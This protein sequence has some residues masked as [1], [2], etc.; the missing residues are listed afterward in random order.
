MQI[1]CL[2]RFAAVAVLCAL[3][4]CDWIGWR[5]PIWLSPAPQ[6][7]AIA[8]VAPAPPAAMPVPK[9][10][11]KSPPPR[12]VPKKVIVGERMPDEVVVKVMEVGRAAFGR[13]FK[14]A[15]D[16]DPLATFKVRLHVELDARGRVTSI[17]A[18]TTNEALASCLTRVG[19]GLPY[20]TTGRPVVVDLPLFYRH[21]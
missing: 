13:C 17:K 3:P 18:D 1:G 6:D 5:A 21:E 7:A 2:R 20:P 9:R 12:E 11:E 10:E 19:S 16:A 4:G 8:P 14:K 15:Y